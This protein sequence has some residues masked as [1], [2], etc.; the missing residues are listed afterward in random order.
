[1][2]SLLGQKFTLAIADLFINNLSPLLRLTVTI[3]LTPRQKMSGPIFIS[4]RREEG[5]W[6]A[7][8]L[9][10]RLI[11]Y[12]NR[13]R[14]FMDIKSIH[15][16]DDFV[17]AIK[18]KVGECD[19]LIAV[20]GDRWLTSDDGRGA[21]RLD[22]PEDFVR[23]EIATALK[24]NIRV[25][26]VLVDG[27]V[28]PPSTDLPDDL[29]PLVSRNALLVRDTSFDDDCRRLVAAIKRPEEEDSQKAPSGIRAKTKWLLAAVLALIAGTGV[30]WFSGHKERAVAL[31]TPT[32]IPILTPIPTPTPTVE[33]GANAAFKRG[34]AAFDK[35]DYDKAIS[36]YTEAIRLKPDDADFYNNRGLA[37]RKKSQYDKAI[38][39]YTEAI[40]LKPDDAEAYVNRGY[41]YDDE[42]EYDKAISDYTEAIRLK[43][44]GAETYNNRGFT[45]YHKKD[46]DKAISDYTEAIRLDPNYVIAYSNRGNAYERQG[47]LDEAKADLA[48]AA[49][50]LKTGH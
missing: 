40:R 3:P 23:M 2:K 36:E 27:A 47:K 49:E 42:K 11:K 46:Y 13:K 22:N 31:S 18:K 35:K 19:V 26:P 4:Y 41:T 29:K 8:R 38:S 12:F 45:S 15:P 1:V 50:L 43:A 24:R 20:I 44:D 34:N 7:G 33:D 14:V 25:I 37:F 16:G 21:R 28:M 6:S 32:P 9:Y 5:R 10:D 48:K 17:K 39:D 30:L